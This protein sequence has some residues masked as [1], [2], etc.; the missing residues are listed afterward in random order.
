MEISDHHDRTLLTRWAAWRD[1]RRQEVWPLK[2]GLAL[3]FGMAL[4]FWT[5]LVL[6]VWMVW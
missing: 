4:V 1:A 6:A 5:L 2:Y 3:I